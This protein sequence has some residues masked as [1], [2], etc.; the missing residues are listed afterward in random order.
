MNHMNIWDLTKFLKEHTGE[1]FTPHEIAKESNSDIRTVKN[2]IRILRNR[3]Y[4]TTYEGYSLEIAERRRL[5]ALRIIKDVEHSIKLIQKEIVEVEK[6]GEDLE[7]IVRDRNLLLK[8][9]SCIA[10]RDTFIRYLEKARYHHN[11]KIRQRNLKKLKLEV[12]SIKNREKKRLESLIAT[13]GAMKKEKE[14]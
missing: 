5:Y 9:S 13:L 8:H 14:E 3:P 11:D 10:V 7:S 1:W 6:I 12:Q 4:E 2:D